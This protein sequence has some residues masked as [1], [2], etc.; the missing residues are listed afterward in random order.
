M[1]ILSFITQFQI[2]FLLLFTGC[3][4][5]LEKLID[6]KVR[7]IFIEKGYRKYALK[8]SPYFNFGIYIYTP[9]IKHTN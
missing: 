2:Q 5:A 7:N 9:D 8:T 3:R 1:N 4:K 6:L